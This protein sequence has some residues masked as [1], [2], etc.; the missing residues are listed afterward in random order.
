MSGGRPTLGV[1]HVDSLSASEEEKLRVKTVLLTMTGELSVQG[2]C[3]RL[4]IGHTRFH[5]LR[6]EV[7]E[8]AVEGARAGRPGRPA[9]EEPPE[10]MKVRR[11]ERRIAT[12]EEELELSLLRT[13]I[14]VTMPHLLRAPW[15]E[16]TEKGGSSPKRKGRRK[17]K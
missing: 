17:R 2:A 7:L 15:S 12:L 3:A 11:L 6:R 14:A 9:K 4:G 1:D 5:E 13:E 10:A 16:R 8:G